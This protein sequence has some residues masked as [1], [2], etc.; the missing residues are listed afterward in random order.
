M[1]PVI[2]PA[3]P[4]V[5]QPRFLGGDNPLMAAIHAGLAFPTY[6]L[7]LAAP[8]TGYA[9]KRLN[10]VMS[11]RELGRVNEL[12]RSRSAL[13]EQTRD[14]FTSWSKETG[15]Y[16]LN[17]STQNAARA[18]VTAQFLADRLRASGIDLDPGRLMGPFQGPGVGRAEENQQNIPGPPAQQKYG[19]R[20]NQKRNF[21]HGGKVNDK[22]PKAQV[23]YTAM[24]RK[25]DRCGLCTMFRAPNGCTAVR[26]VISPRGWCKLFEAKPVERANGGGVSA[27]NIEHEPT[28]AQRR[29]LETTLRIMSACMVSILR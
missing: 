6:G 27:G 24:S 19:G 13:A 4:C 21:A 5:L 15:S 18:G 26:G 14:A 1:W 12:L 10:D 8:A 20:I 16:S 2:L 29:R 3:T 28:E 23:N 22:E 9:L 11:A 7:S 25:T 17:P